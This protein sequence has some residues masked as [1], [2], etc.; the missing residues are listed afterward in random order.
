MGSEKFEP[1]IKDE[2]TIETRILTAGFENDMSERSM[3]YNIA[4]T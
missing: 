3:D 1:L 4:L 2:L